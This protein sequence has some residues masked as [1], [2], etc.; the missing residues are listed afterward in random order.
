MDWPKSAGAKKLTNFNL[1]VIIFKQCPIHPLSET[2]FFSY[3]AMK[4]LLPALIKLAPF[5]VTGQPL[6]T[7]VEMSRPLP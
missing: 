1:Q 6:S 5:I 7:W 3:C 4:A 2:L